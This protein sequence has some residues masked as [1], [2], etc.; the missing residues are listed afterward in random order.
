MS[1][2]RPTSSAG[3]PD[4]LRDGVPEFPDHPTLTQIAQRQM[5]IDTWD[6]MS[7]DGYRFA[8]PGAIISFLLTAIMVVLV[9][10]PIPPNWPWDIP[11]CILS[12][13]SAVVMVVCGLL[14]LDRPDSGPRPELLEIVP[15]TRAENLQLM[16]GQGAEPYGAICACPG[17]GDE[18]THLVRRPTDSEPDWATVTR[19]CRVCNREWV[20]A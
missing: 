14:W 3:D 11:L 4:R 20:Q 10:T 7:V 18:C 16:S 12:I 1:S 13:F 15:F 9:L 5:Q 19:C 8:K 2:V 6:A 17:C